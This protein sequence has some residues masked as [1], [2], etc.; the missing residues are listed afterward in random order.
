MAEPKIRLFVKSVKTVTGCV[1]VEHEVFGG[2][3]LDRP[4]RVKIEGKR[5]DGTFRLRQFATQIEP[6]HEFI[7]SE[8]P[9]KVVETV[10]DVSRKYSLEVEV[11]DI[12]RENVLHRIIKERQAK[13]KIF[14]TLTTDSGQRIEGNMTGEKVESFISKIASERRKKYL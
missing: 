14:P 1:E 12:A 3:P 5:S 6:K 8:D 4:S 10:K 13:I 9:Q 11:I 2:M 7:L